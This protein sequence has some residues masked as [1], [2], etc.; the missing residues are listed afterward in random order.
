MLA[1]LI[2]YHVVRAFLNEAGFN[3]REDL[4]DTV[5]SARAHYDDMP[6]ITFQTLLDDYIE[7]TP[8]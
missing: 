6:P 7:G 3:T 2:E 1:D 5:N 8:T 4:V